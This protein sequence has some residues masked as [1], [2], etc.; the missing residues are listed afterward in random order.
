MTCAVH[1]GRL[2]GRPAN[3]RG[4]ALAWEGRCLNPQIGSLA[5]SRVEHYRP[6]SSAQPSRL[7]MHCN[8]EV[9]L[10]PV[11][12][13]FGIEVSPTPCNGPAGMPGQTRQPAA[14][15]QTALPAPGGIRSGNR[16]QSATGSHFGSKLVPAQQW[17]CADSDSHSAD[18]RRGNH[19]VIVEAADHRTHSGDCGRAGH[20]HPIRAH[21]CEQ[22]QPAGPGRAAVG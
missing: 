16:L 18:R 15:A 1:A 20:S 22:D 12:C 5:P 7:C 10:R 21:A 4:V 11:R 19:H 3:R 6:A 17:T 8:R 13:R 2:T 14:R 9:P